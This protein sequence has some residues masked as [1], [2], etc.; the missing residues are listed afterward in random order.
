MGI[1]PMAVVDSRLSVHSIQNLRVRRC[2][3]NAERYRR[4]HQQPEIMIAEKAAD[5][6]LSQV[7]YS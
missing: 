5:I 3:D 1:D 6:V 4:Q 7:A 2:D